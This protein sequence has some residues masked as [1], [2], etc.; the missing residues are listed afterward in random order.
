AVCAAAGAG[1]SSG[2]DGRAKSEAGVG[3]KTGAATPRELRI[4]TWSHFV[5]A[6]DDWF[7]NEYVKRW[8]ERNDVEVV[9]DHLPLNELP[10]RGDAE[11]AAKRG[12]DLFWF[13]NPRASLEDDVIDHREIVEEVRGKAGEMTRHVERSVFNP[14][15][16]RFFA[17]PD[18][19]A[20]G[21][22]N[23]RVDLWDQ[24]EPGL[25]PSTWDVVRRAGAPLKTS[26]HPLGLGISTDIDSNWTLNTLLHSYGGSIQD[27]NANLAINTPATVEAVKTCAEIYRTGMTD[28]VFAWDGASNNRL[29]TSG[30]GSLILNAVSAV[31]AAEQE[32]PELAAKIALA[33][34]PIG[35]SGDQPRCTNVVASYVI[36]KFSPNIDLAKRF[37]VDLA[38]SYR[39]AFLHSGFYNLPAFGG[40]VPDLGGLVA[41]D[42]SARPSDKYALLAEAVHWSTNVGSPGSFNAAVDEIF[43]AFIL[44]KMFSAAAR[45]QMSPADAVAA[46]EAEMRPIFD[47]WRE[48]GK[49]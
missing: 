18:H 4:A 31:R 29:L 11:A 27:E 22:V 30:R 49:I 8:G 43:N 33:P 28:E 36:W 25:R 6:Y 12:H 34:V 46:A 40:L 45:G 41:N 42:P 9:V 32:A 16:N 15:T 26:G 47:K 13:L 37:L 19:W 14:R 20:P 39:D 38:L 24:L 35:P 1:C 44:S 3:T 21:P 23:Y 5:P 10:I 48:R 7:D 2:G 17:F